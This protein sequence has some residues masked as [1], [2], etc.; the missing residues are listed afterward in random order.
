MIDFI[1]SQGEK[2]KVYIKYLIAGGLAS[3]ADLVLLFIFTDWFKLWYLFSAILAFCFAIFLSFSLQKFWTFR[4]D[5]RDRIY[6]Q[7]TLFFSV[8]VVNLVINTVLIYLF[9]DFIHLWYIL[10]QIIASGLIAI[11]SFIIYKFLI[12]QQKERSGIQP[13]VLITTGIYPPDFRGPATMLEALPQALR[14]RSLLVK[15]LT[16]SDIPSSKS[17]QEQ[18]EVYRVLRKEPAWLRYPKFFWHLWWLSHWADIVYV[19]DIYG[20]G[21]L[22]YL[23]KKLSGRKYIVRFAGDSAWEK[24][25]ADGRTNDYIVDFQKKHYT[26]DIE[27][28][29]R[30]RQ[31]ILL[32]ADRTIAV[33]QFMADLAQLIGAKPEKIK[34][35]YNSIDFIKEGEINQKF[36]QE[37]K[38]QYGREG[39]IIVTSGQLVLWKGMVGLIKCLPAIKQRFGSINLLVLGEGQELEN[40]KALAR[41]LGLEQEVHFLG[42]IKR[43]QM[44]NYFNAAD[45]YILNTNYEGLSHTLLEVMKAGTPIITTNSGGNPEV[46]ANGQEGILI[47]FD[48]AE[49]LVQAAGLLLS[50]FDL[51]QKYTAAAKEKLKKFNWATVV[52]ETDKLIRELI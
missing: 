20:V 21:Y 8:A 6:Q 50:N 5:S 1:L 30:R 31:K 38:K 25:A 42:K 34:V 47:D 32:S 36:V 18:E 39:K 15:I 9:V 10:A 40:L 46:I 16:F 27:K 35:I 12:F 11:S 26:P 13:K 14:Q 7:F 2:Y 23:V 41:T 51:A 44:M 48:D 43:Q 24:A 3:L 17:E 19:T 33:S 22:V 29:K 4:E 45:L 49:A 52:A 37:I 28:L